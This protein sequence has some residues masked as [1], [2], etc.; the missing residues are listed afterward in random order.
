MV[1]CTITRLKDEKMSFREITTSH[2]NTVFSKKSP[3][4]SNNSK[5]VDQ[6]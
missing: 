1:I 5:V 4:D 6:V 3:A 2:F